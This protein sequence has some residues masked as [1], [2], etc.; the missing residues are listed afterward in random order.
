VYR[1]T[2]TVV[3]ALAALILT[4]AALAPV[5]GA[6]S[7]STA[8]LVEQRAG[9]R[10]ALA[11]AR[12]R[13]TQA[14]ADVAAALAL[15]LEVHGQTGAMPAPIVTPPSGMDQTLAARLLAD[16]IVSDDEIAALQQRAA[17]RRR[18]VRRLALQVERLSARIRARRQVEHWARAHRWTPLI[19]IAARTYGI[20]P[21]GLQ[22]MMM[23]ESGGDP[24]VV[25]GIYN[26]LF[27]YT[28][29]EWARHWN[30]WRHESIYDGW[31]QIRATAL[32][33]SKGMGPS[34]WPNTYPMS[35]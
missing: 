15:Q 29:S 21:H 22:H 34:Q 5:A 24:S 12:A 35:F 32:A 33:L 3:I 31:A 25:G 2:T 4:V 8:Q 7:P 1:R 19:E 26:G 17:H 18:I 28:H 6:T 13:S 14:A 30:P 27:Q 11:Q 10:H 16:G 20:D 9:A 23:L